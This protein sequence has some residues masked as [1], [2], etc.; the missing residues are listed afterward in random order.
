MTYIY[1]VRS[2]PD[3]FERVSVV[4]PHWRC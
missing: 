2:A 3:A 1:V 4:N